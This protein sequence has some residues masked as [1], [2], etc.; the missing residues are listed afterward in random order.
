MQYRALRACLIKEVQSSQHLPLSDPIPVACQLEKQTLF[1]TGAQSDADV[2]A[3]QGRMTR[4][5]VNAYVDAKSTVPSRP[6]RQVCA[7]DG[8]AFTH[9]SCAP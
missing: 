3:W 5:Y 8:P 6:P 1:P 9:Q 7:R 4:F 2:Q